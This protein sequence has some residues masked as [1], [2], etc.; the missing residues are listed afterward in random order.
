MSR[1]ILGRKP[2]GMS[3][4]E[5]SEIEDSANIYNNADRDLGSH[6]KRGG[7]QKKI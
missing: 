1:I 4:R 3:W 6:T 7:T 5:W 2:S